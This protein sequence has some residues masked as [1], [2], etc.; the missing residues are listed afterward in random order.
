MNVVDKNEMKDNTG[1]L[2]QDGRTGSVFP[3]LFWKN[4]RKITVLILFFKK[5]VKI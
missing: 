2:R 5:M 1:K 3:F 4:F